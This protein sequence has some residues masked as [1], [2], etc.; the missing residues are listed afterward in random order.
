MSDAESEDSSEPYSDG[1]NP[2]DATDEQPP[3]ERVQDALEYKSAWAGPLPHPS[4]LRGYDDVVPGAA[5]EIMDAWRE[6]TRHRHAQEKRDLGWSIFES[7]FGRIVALVFVLAALACATYAAVH[8]AEW[9][10][11]IL[12]GGTIASSIWA[13]VRQRSDSG[14]D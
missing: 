5:R 4:D 7:V 13:F 14:K 12:G 11:A 3:T 10:G 6:E 1:S 8:G 2:L 9:F